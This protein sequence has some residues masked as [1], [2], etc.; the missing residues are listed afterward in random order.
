MIFFLTVLLI[1]TGQT[2]KEFSMA[3]LTV[4]DKRYR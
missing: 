4:T 1:E 3:H 2:L